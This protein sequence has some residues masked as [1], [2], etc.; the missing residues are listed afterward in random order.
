MIPIIDFQERVLN[1]PVKKSEDFDLDYSMKIR[2]LVEKY[3]IKYNPEELI[4]DNDT[5]DSVFH[6]G[7]DLLTDVGIYHMDTQ[8]VIQFTKE[9]VLAIAAE[10]K[11]KPATAVFGQG[12]D[13]M[14]ISYRTGKDSRPPVLYA[15][16]P[17]VATE[18]DFVP[19]VL[20]FAQEKEVVG[21][22]IMPGLA[23]LG[24][25]TPKAGT[26]SEIH[27]ALWEQERLLEVLKKV[28]RLGMNMGL[29]ATASEL[30]AIYECVKP[31]RREPWNIQIG[32]HIIPEMKLDWAALL[33]AHYCQD[34]GIIPWQSA[35]TMI[36]GLCRDAA[37]A[38]VGM[39]ANMLGQLSYGQGP[40]IS[41]F[42]NHMDGSW[43]TLST[44]WCAGAA[45]RAS[46]RNI[47]A[48]TGSSISGAYQT[49]RHPVS[50]L[51]ASAVATVYTACGLAYAWIAG[52][53]GLEARLIGEVMNATA[54]MEK[55]KANDLAK[56]I[57]VKVDERIGEISAQKPFLDAYD[58]DGKTTTPKPDYE[59]GMMKVKEELA[60]MGVPY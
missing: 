3:S 45:M 19:Y 20:S 30:G 28:D 54:G 46:E 15:G 43:G 56:K 51:Q 1:G 31:G 12:K 25:I 37:D 50:F 26:L 35:M 57:Q 59:K 4:V 52:H 42:P 17:A 36:G 16:A 55:D 47:K 60:A 29:L 9:E 32:V 2:E 24:D 33:K 53:T 40:T 27:V 41:I 34:R 58:W 39:V 11:A 49:W 18:E 10:R 38:A 22:G 13:E 6:A 8:R 44:H 14:S 23:K 21:M 7:V 48:A 5:A